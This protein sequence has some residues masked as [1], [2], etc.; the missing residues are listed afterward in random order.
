MVF[1]LG[2]GRNGGVWTAVLATLLIGDGVA[3]R[4]AE[5]GELELRA[6]IEICDVFTGE[7]RARTSSAVVFDDPTW[8]CETNDRCEAE[9]RARTRM[10][11]V[12]F[13]RVFNGPTRIQVEAERP[14][15]RGSVLLALDRSDWKPRLADLAA[16][17]FDPPRL[18][19]TNRAAIEGPPLV[20]V[21]APRSILV[22]SVLLGAGAVAA[23]IGGAL[24]SSSKGAGSQLDSMLLF[25]DRH[26]ELADRQ[27][28]HGI[29]AD[30]AFGIA[31]AAAVAAVVM[32][33]VD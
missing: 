7:L 3:V 30:V 26:R 33:F 23:L 21:E 32:F 17:L 18:P 28:A 11:D 24:G 12:V 2:F 25:A 31:G 4:L 16:S 27:K 6:A 19:R 20:P 1:A 8:D 22:P 14:G 13:V 9:I 10:D 29:G 5:V 15:R